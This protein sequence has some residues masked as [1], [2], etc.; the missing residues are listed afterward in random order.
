LSVL[1]Y[2][3]GSDSYCSLVCTTPAS[4]LT[5]YEADSYLILEQTFHLLLKCLPPMYLRKFLNCPPY[6]RTFPA[7]YSVIHSPPTSAILPT[8]FPTSKVIP[9]KLFRCPSQI[10]SF[11]FNCHLLPE[12]IYWVVLVFLRYAL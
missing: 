2:W 7:Q 11:L 9:V 12:Q 6:L 4:F 1:W 3:N 5:W 10:N 8:Q